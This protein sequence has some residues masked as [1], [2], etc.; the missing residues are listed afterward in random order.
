MQ[1]RKQRKYKNN[2]PL[3]VKRKMMVSSLSKDL[4]NEYGIRSFP[5]RKGDN[6]LVTTGSFKGKKGKVTEVSIKRMFVHVEGVE[7]AKGDGT[8]SFY[9][10]NPSNLV[11]E[12][13]N[14]KDKLRAE[15]LEKLKEVKKS[16]K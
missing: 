9:P 5:I 13:F 1:A 15:K 10:V 2:A 3:H 8:K 6:V 12:K 7:Q 4:R 11:I 16:G 14:L